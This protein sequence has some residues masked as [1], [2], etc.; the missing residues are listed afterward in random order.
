VVAG[1]A[2]RQALANHDLV[3]AY[4]GFFTVVPIA[5]M[6]ALGGLMMAVKRSTPII[7]RLEMQNVPPEYCSGLSFWPWRAQ[8]ARALRC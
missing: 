1:K 5:R 2:E 3:I 7:P 8:R 4:T 6:A